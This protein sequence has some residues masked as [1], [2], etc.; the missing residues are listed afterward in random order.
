MEQKEFIAKYKEMS[1]KEID[2]FIAEHQE[3]ELNSSTLGR[4]FEAKFIKKKTGKSDKVYIEE[5][6]QI[7]NSF[8]IRNGSNWSR[9]DNA[10]FL[11]RNYVVVNHKTEGHI[12]SIEVVRKKVYSYW[13]P[14]YRKID[15][16]LLD[17]LEDV[18]KTFQVEKSGEVQKRLFSY[19]EKLIQ[20]NNER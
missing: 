3:E 5:L 4:I 1:M 12:S 9:N 18:Y 15:L 11:G 17:E 7:H 10:C 8:A 16:E 6:K 13:T 14:K 20:I 19:I 2:D